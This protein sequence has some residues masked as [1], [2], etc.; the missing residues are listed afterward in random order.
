M[1]ATPSNQPTTA[2]PG[3]VALDALVRRQQAFAAVQALST[4]TL[5]RLERAFLLLR[6]PGAIRPG[7]TE[8]LYH[9]RGDADTYIVLLTPHGASCNCPDAQQG[10]L[11]K[12]ALAVILYQ[13]FR[14]RGPHPPATTARHRVVPSTISA[15]T[16]VDPDCRVWP[17]PL[18][19]AAG[20]DCWATTRQMFRRVDAAMYRHHERTGHGVG[21]C[22]AQRRADALWQELA[23][24]LGRLAD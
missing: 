16:A 3:V 19:A 8:S 7:S 11:C 6:R 22:A 14:G 13:R 24:A 20:G 10:H 12:H 2:D 17:T 23:G 18:G 1:A 21:A 5:R 15:D 4:D 9:V